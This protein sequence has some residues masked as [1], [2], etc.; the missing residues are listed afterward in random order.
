VQIVHERGRV[1]AGID[2]IGSAYD[3]DQL[4]LLE[5]LARERLHAG[6]QVLEFEPA[7][8]GRADAGAAVVEATSS[9]LLWEALVGVYDA[10]GFAVVPHGRSD[11]AAGGGGRIRGGGASRRGS[12]A[13]RRRRWWGW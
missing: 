3:A 13:S 11:L 8:G 10:L 2:Q 6:Q 12:S 9:R 1:V 5:E 4:A 7:V